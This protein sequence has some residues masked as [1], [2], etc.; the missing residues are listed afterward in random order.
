VDRSERDLGPSASYSLTLR[1]RI[2][3]QPGSFACVVGAIGAMLGAIDLVR[4]Q[5]GVA[6]RDVAVACSDREPRRSGPRRRPGAGG[7]CRSG[8][9][10]KRD[11]RRDEARRGPG[12]RQ[13]HPD[14]ELHT[15]C[16]IP[17]VF[18]AHVAEA[19]AEAALRTGVARKLRSPA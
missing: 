16:I 17:S 5:D 4:E 13:R 6:V 10:R 19:V 1:L 12:D 2:P 7:G 9:P 8:C 3:Q 11:Q 18:H 14:E 15:E